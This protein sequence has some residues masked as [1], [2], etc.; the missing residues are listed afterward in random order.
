MKRKTFLLTTG[1]AVLAVASVPVIKYYLNGTKSYDPLI[2]PQ[3]LGNFCDEKTIRE[4]GKR[5]REQMPMENEKVKLQQILLTDKNGKLIDA[6]DKY[7]VTELLDKK[8]LEDFVNY[9]IHILNGWVISTTE[10]RQ[11]ALFSLI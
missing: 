5:Y 10:A 11:C 6:S 9:N 2:M 3:E 4:I 8:I 1:V 7:A